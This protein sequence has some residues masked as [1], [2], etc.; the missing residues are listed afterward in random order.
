VG[1]GLGAV[2][3]SLDRH[4]ALAATLGTEE[5][6]ETDS[7]RNGN[8]GNN[9]SDRGSVGV[10][11]LNGLGALETDLDTKLGFATCLQPPDVFGLDQATEGSAQTTSRRTEGQ[12]SDTVHLKVARVGG[13]EEFTQ[14]LRPDVADASGEAV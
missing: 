11:A 14:D 9:G 8:Q 10:V 6:E 7:S 13:G 3:V 1:V 2:G 12:D 5:K 4:V